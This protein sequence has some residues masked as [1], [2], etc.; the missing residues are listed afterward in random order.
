MSDLLF[1]NIVL[2]A[3]HAGYKAKNAILKYLEAQGYSVIDLGTNCSKSV[4][5]P[6]YADKIASFLKDNKDYKGILFCGTG[7]GIS[8]A[9]NRHKHIRAALCHNVET[10]NL[11][12]EHNDANVLAIG[13]RVVK[14]EDHPEIV[15][16]FLNTKFATGRHARRVLKLRGNKFIA[17][18]KNFLIMQKNV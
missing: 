10:A 16:S 11:A 9:A 12:R 18:I 1:K 6:D 3:D 2:A 5:Y 15:E 17:K 8:I 4:D 14:S 7:I 13:S